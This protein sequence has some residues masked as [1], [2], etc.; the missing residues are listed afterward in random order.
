MSRLSHILIA[1]VLLIQS[2]ALFA[3][4][5]QLNANGWRDPRLPADAP[6]PDGIPFE[7]WAPVADFPQQETC[8]A[9]LAQ[10]EQASTKRTQRRP[11][12][13]GSVVLT[14]RYQCVEQ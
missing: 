8:L 4:N 10:R 1:W 3:D 9:A 12:R 5:P 6:P 7:L 11:D 13:P 14:L 2:V